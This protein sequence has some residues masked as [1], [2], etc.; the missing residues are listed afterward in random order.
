[1]DITNFCNFQSASFFHK[2]IYSSSILSTMIGLESEDRKRSPAEMIRSCTPLA[3]RKRCRRSV[4]LAHRRLCSKAA[5]VPLTV[6]AWRCQ[7]RPAR[8]EVP[9]RRSMW[10]GRPRPKELQ[11]KDGVRSIEIAW[12]RESCICLFVFFVVVSEKWRKFQNS[13]SSLNGFKFRFSSGGDVCRLCQASVNLFDLQDAC[14]FFPL[15]ASPQSQK[16]L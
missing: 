12:K 6:V 7:S 1:M 2:K 11:G 10:A 13:A 5:K 14:V 8:Q 15:M 9:R 16:N 3:R 4:W